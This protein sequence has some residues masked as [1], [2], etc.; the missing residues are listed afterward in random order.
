MNNNFS[1]YLQMCANNFTQINWQKWS[2]NLQEQTSQNLSHLQS[3]AHNNTQNLKRNAQL[4]LESM[5]QSA[6]INNMEEIVANQCNLL[7]DIAANNAE[8][9]RENLSCISANLMN[10]CSNISNAF[11]EQAQKCADPC[12]HSK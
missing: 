6:S 3:I 8:N 7:K 1:E 10:N 5:K 2:D 4:L 12:N 11:M 9:F